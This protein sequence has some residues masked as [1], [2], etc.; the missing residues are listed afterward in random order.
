MAGPIPGLSVLLSGPCCGWLRGLLISP[1]PHEPELPAAE[2]SET[3]LWVPKFNF[4][5][6][7]AY[8]LKNPITIPKGAK[9]VVTAHYDNSKKN[10]YNPD[11][12]KDVRWGDP[13]YDEMMI[14]WLDI[15]VENPAKAAKPDA[16]ARSGQK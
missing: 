14:G 11:A 6:Q 7:A 9:L 8:V 4:N 2:F 13:T 3:L 10:R 1:R 12:T 16:S 15:M 5:W